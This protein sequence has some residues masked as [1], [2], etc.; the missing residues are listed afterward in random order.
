MPNPPSDLRYAPLPSDADITPLA[1]LVSVAFGIAPDDT[2]TWLS[3]DVK[4]E[5]L[6]AVSRDGRPIACVGRV[7]LGIYLGGRSI[8]QVGVLGVAV[9]PEARGGGVA[10]HMMRECV[11]E[12]HAD[13]YAISTLY[14]ALHPLYRGVGYENAGLLVD[15]TIPAGMFESGDKGTWRP[16]TDADIPAVKACYADYARHHHGMLDRTGYIWDRVRRNREADNL[17]FLAEDDAG[18]VEAYCFH[19]L[20]KMDAPPTTT[21]SATGAPLR[22]ADLAWRT[23]RGFRRL[24]GFLKGYASLVGEIGMSLPLGS[25]LLAGV[26]DWRFATK[27]RTPWMMRILDVPKA[28]ESRGYAPCVSA[29]LTLDIT[30]ELIPANTGRWTLTVE[31]G[32]GRVEP[33]QAH[34]RENSNKN[35]GGGDTLRCAIRDLAPLYTGHISAFALRGA[36]RVECDDATAEACEAV[37]AAGSAPSMVDMF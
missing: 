23:P 34:N 8:P 19:G 30:D 32:T 27:V 16:I 9:A 5:N 22:L 17:G 29:R 10:G 15:A 12:M 13:G 36:G 2:S 26:P 20:A 24:L 11:R 1:R 28:L 33:S 4:P 6:R 7:P 14:S 21:G 18:G 31:G 37:F 25:P 3:R 35:S